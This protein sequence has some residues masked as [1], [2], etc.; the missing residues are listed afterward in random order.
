[1]KLKHARVGGLSPRRGR[2]G[3]ESSESINTV[4]FSLILKEGPLTADERN[5]LRLCLKKLDNVSTMRATV[6]TPFCPSP[7][8]TMGAHFVAD[9]F[10]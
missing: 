1:M 8:T 9:I 10:Q 2:E 3:T 4:V 5:I 7:I 6:Y